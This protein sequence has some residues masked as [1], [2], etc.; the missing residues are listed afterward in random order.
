MT[1]PT[2]AIR[3]VKLSEVQIAAIQLA[4]GQ[5]IGDGTLP[6]A[7]TKAATS[8]LAAIKCQ[9]GGQMI[10]L[11]KRLAIQMGGI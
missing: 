5:M 11:Q 3:T 2:N 9:I 8:A 4:L 10:G 7:V 1:I 6:V